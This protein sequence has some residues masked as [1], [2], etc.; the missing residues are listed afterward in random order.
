MTR[1]LIADDKKVAADGGEVEPGGEVMT[2]DAYQRWLECTCKT[3]L[4]LAAVAYNKLEWDALFEQT[5]QSCAAW[6]Q[7][8]DA[9]RRQLTLKG[10]GP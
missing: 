8:V 1:A 7:P 5:K 6:S 3:C 2:S 10:L 4:A 9:D